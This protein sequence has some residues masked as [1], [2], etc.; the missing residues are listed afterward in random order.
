MQIQVPHHKEKQSCNAYKEATYEFAYNTHQ[1]HHAV[2]VNL[3]LDHFNISLQLNEQRNYKD[4]QL[5]N[6]TLRAHVNLR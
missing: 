2:I 6:I 4:L 1:G 3:I 5:I